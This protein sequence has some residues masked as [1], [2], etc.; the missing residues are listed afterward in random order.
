[1]P[2][3]GKEARERL[4][5]AALTLFAARGFD[6]VTTAE[7]AALAGVT[8]RTFFRH[9]PDKREV[10]FDGERRLTEWVT[11]ALT[12]VPAGT[13]PWPTMRRVVDLL[14]PPLEANRADGDRL[15]AIAAATPAVQERAAAKEAHLIGLIADQLTARGAAPE[16]ASLVAR[17]GWGVLAHAIGSWRRAPGTRL[18][19]HV[20]RAFDLLGGLVLG[21][22]PSS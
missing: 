3:S 13:A 8:E 15:A 19:P 20:D 16:E 7:I 9:F 22:Q 12:S 5:N 18:Q 4:E 10:L 14:V 17:T 11:E 1:M 21:P 6:A 2:R